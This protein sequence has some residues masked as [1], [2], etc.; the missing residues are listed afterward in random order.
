MNNNFSYTGK[1]TGISGEKAGMSFLIANTG[2][3]IGRD[4]TVCHIIM[5]K[6]AGVSRIHCFITY[7]NANGTYVIS[8]RNSTY[9]TFTESGQ[10][11][12]PGNS[13]ALKHGERFY[14]GSPQNM[15]EVG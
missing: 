9:G 1:V 2:T 14:L 7:N 13:I 4:P 5:R 12:M 6:S 3:M 11:I 8:D 15:F 10:K